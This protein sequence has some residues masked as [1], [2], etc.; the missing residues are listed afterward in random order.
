MTLV[1]PTILYSQLEIAMLLKTDNLI[2]GKIWFPYWDP[3]HPMC[4]TSLTGGELVRSVGS[5]FKNKF[6]CIS[7][8]IHVIHQGKFFTSLSMPAEED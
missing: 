5:P 1:S 2:S 4:W 7:L 8:G 6:S 3:Y